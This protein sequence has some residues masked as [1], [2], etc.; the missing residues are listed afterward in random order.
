MLFLKSKIYKQHRMAVPK[1]FHSF[2]RYSKRH[3]SFLCFTVHVLHKKPA[4]YSLYLALIGTKLRFVY[5]QFAPSG[6]LMPFKIQ[7]LSV[8]SFLHSFYKTRQIKCIILLLLL[9]LLAACSPS[10]DL[11]NQLATLAKN[12]PYVVHLIVAVSYVMGV[13]AIYSGFYTL[14]LY[15]DARTMMATQGTGF[16]G[17]MVKIMIG[18]FLMMLPGTIMIAINSL[19]A[20]GVDPSSI[21]VYPTLGK[22]WEAWEQ[23][24]HGIIDLIRVFGYI[25]FVRGLHMLAKATKKEQNITYG[26]GFM[27]VIGGIL[28]IN[29][30]GTIDI[31]RHSFG[32]S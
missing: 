13:W 11:N 29:I 16:G 2:I 9:P 7:L 3:V 22:G 32:I 6:W 21:M 28:S 10:K 12:L 27:H 20:S 18:A 1:L 14:K 30:V 17:P 19:W 15:G 26:K 23:A 31:I 24:I 5:F 8:L 25:S 4:K